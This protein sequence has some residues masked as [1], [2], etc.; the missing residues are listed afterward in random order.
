MVVLASNYDGVGTPH[1]PVEVRYCLDQAHRSH[2]VGANSAAV[3]M[4]RSALEH[5]LVG[6]GFKEGM[7]GRKIEKLEAAIEAGT[8]PAWTQ[9]IGPDA[10]EAMKDLGNTA[11]HA[12][13]G[14]ISQQAK[15][16]ADLVL[17]VTR[18]FR[19]LLVA[20]YDNPK[21]I[22]ALQA[23]LKQSAATKLGTL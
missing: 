17:R 23:S 20:V 4:Y 7:L 6:P 16:D 2:A 18:M 8:A 10:L 3:A 15:F 21:T 9:H 14:D 22:E 1:T 11:V 12:N 13:G 19:L 5:L